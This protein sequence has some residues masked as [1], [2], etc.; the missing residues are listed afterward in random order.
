MFDSHKCV[1]AMILVKTETLVRTRHITRLEML[2][3]Y[4]SLRLTNT[5]VND[6]GVITPDTL[7]RLHFS[8]RYKLSD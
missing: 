8:G 6:T 1:E 2:I 4:V 5:H 7:L 3:N